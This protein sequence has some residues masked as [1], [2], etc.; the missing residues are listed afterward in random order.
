MF[1]RDVDVSRYALEQCDRLFGWLSQHFEIVSDE[2][3][4][5]ISRRSVGVFGD[6]IDDRLGQVKTSRRELLD[7]LR[8]IAASSSSFL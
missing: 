4:R 5:Q 6:A 7:S 2:L 3:H 1:D 8:W